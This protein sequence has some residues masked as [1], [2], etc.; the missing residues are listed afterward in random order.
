[1]EQAYYEG[2]EDGMQQPQ[3][4][5]RRAAADKDLDPQYSIFDKANPAK[6]ADKVGDSIMDG[7]KAALDVIKKPIDEIKKFIDFLKDLPKNV[8]N[9]LVGFF[10]GAVWIA[11]IVACAVGFAMLSGPIM[12]AFKTVRAGGDVVGSLIA[13]P[14][15]TPLPKSSVLGGVTSFIKRGGGANSMIARVKTEGITGLLSR[16]P[17][18]TTAAGGMTS[19]ASALGR[20]SLAPITGMRPTSVASVAPTPSMATAAAA[21]AT[22]PRVTGLPPRV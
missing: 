12:N 9:W 15:H 1:M 2:F 20:P 4:R 14:G 11:V 10:G 18:G 16:T 8:W 7:L 22:F 19:M 5:Q 17:A 21:A 13:K 3:R 6:I